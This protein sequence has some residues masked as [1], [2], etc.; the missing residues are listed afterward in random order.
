MAFWGIDLHVKDCLYQ[1]HSLPFGLKNAFT[2]FQR[3]MDYI[4]IGLGFA[5]SYINDIIIFSLTLEDHMHHL[6]EIFRRVE[7]H[8][9]KLHPCKC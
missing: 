4:L 7:D 9:L 1:W 6:Q 5:K 3:V 8:N 2:K